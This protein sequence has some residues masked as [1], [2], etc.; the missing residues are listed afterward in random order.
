M[1]NWDEEDYNKWRNYPPGDYM[2]K[3]LCGRPHPSNVC[4]FKSD[5]HSVLLS[6]SFKPKPL[7]AVRIERLPKERTVTLL[8]YAVHVWSKRSPIISICQTVES[9]EEIHDKIE[10][11]KAAVHRLCHHDGRNERLKSY[12]MEHKFRCLECGEEWGYDSSG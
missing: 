6:L 5:G 8:G 7:R 9:L 10:E 12:A 2:Y 1:N 3:N 4:S 11:L